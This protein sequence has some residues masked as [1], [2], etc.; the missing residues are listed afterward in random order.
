MRDRRRCCNC[1]TD[2]LP[3][4]PPTSQQ[5]PPNQDQIIRHQGNT[6]FG[7]RGGSAAEQRRGACAPPSSQCNKWEYWT[8]TRSNKWNRIFCPFLIYSMCK[9]QFDIYISTVIQIFYTY[10]ICVVCQRFWRSQLW[11]HSL[12]LLDAPE[13][14]HLKYL[15]T[16]LLT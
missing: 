2:E 12:S 10:G 9:A 6:L 4:P 14:F 7:A 3:R 8:P 13:I 1:W 16:S 11:S 5:P 15:S